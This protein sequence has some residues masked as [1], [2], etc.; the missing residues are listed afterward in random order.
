M[1]GNIVGTAT[2]EVRGKIDPLKQDFQQARAE[3]EKFTKAAGTDATRGVKQFQQGVQQL[4]NTTKSFN[5]SAQSSVDEVKKFQRGMQDA[6][7]ATR[8][9]GASMDVTALAAR[10]LGAAVGAALAIHNFVDFQSGIAEVSTLVDTSKVSMDQLEHSVLQAG[11][12]FGNLGAQAK[13]MYQIVSAG[14]SDAATATDVLNASNKLA[15]GGVTDVATAADGLTSVLNAYGSKVEGTTAVSDAMFVAMR[16]GKTTIGE[17][18]QNIGQVAPI[19]AQAGVKFDDLLASIS[20]LTKGGISTNV[21]ITGMRQLLV[22]VVKPSTE[23]SKLAK[24]LG[25]DWSLAGLQA[26]G[27]SGFLQDVQEK[28]KG[29]AAQMAI[30]AGS[31]EGLTPL[32]ALTGTQAGDFANILGDMADKT[33]ETET[34]YKKMENTIGQQASRVWAALQAEVFGTGSAL[35]DVLVPALKFAADHMDVIIKV[36]EVL[37]GAYIPALAVAIGTRLVQAFNAL[38]IAIATNPL[39]LIITVLAAVIAAMY[40]FRHELAGWAANVLRGFQYMVNGAIDHLNSLIDGLHSLSNFFGKGKAFLGPAGAILALSDSL[41]HIGK[42]DLSGTIKSLD[43]YSASGEAAAAEMAGLQKKTE[44]VQQVQQGLNDATD[45]GTKKL[46]DAQ[47]AAKRLAEERAKTIKGLQDEVAQIEQ[48]IALAK[49]QGATE[50]SLADA[51]ERLATIQKL[52]LSANSKEAQQI[53]DLIAKRRELNRELNAAKEAMDLRSQIA[54]LE[55]INPLYADNSKSLTDI[56]AAREKA[57]LFQKLGIEADSA[58]AKVLSDLLDRRRALNEEEAKRKLSDS[59]EQQIKGLND[60]IAVLGMS[61]EAEAAY[62]AEQELLNQA[63]QAGITITPELSSQ[64][65]QYAQTIGATTGQLDRLQKQLEATKQTQ[66]FFSN[67]FLDALDGLIYSGKSL[68]D[69]FSNLALEISKAAL[70]ASL[71]GTGPLASLF[72]GSSSGG[73]GIL[74]NLFGSLLSGLTGGSSAMSS[75]LSSW[76]S[77][78]LSGTTTFSALVAHN[79]A[80]VV[81]AGGPRRNAPVATFVNAPRFHDGLKPG[82]FPAILQAGETVNP[83]GHQ[84]KSSGTTIV[85]N[86]YPRDYDSFRRTQRQ[87]AR[88]MKQLYSF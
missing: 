49:E 38:K 33:G 24:Q 88:R 72:G 56:A 13:A 32:L 36:A 71:L 27:L 16:D 76:D 3:T 58:E 11:A 54:L 1:A 10:R 68:G 4:D 66:D 81:G 60:Q 41:G 84:E 42:V 48:S 63:Q 82:E 61:K 30:L 18:S 34:A 44:A 67:G 15:I 77:S 22:N 78:S 80:T 50:D 73:G 5:R 40:V 17:L 52:Q 25:I 85:Q 86:V 12:T 8:A 62:R 2:V 26:K 9:A 19:A 14:A 21:A 28:T 46:T 7:K 35:N 69:V 74:S 20:A 37:A 75:S 31:V 39:G 59:A 79:G 57:T 70:Q 65:R 23:A 51:K 43:D 55:Q 83:R 6:D 45:K 29:N 64:I 53:T 47:K 87:E